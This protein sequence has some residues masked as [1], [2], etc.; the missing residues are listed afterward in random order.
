[1]QKYEI[2]EFFAFLLYTSSSI[3][4]YPFFTFSS[5]LPFQ[6]VNH[7]ITL[8]YRDHNETSPDGCQQA[9]IC[10]RA[11]LSWSGHEVPLPPQSMPSRRDMTSSTFMP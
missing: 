1:M 10:L 5:Y 7:K 2:F 9:A 3:T 11:Q 6:N 8:P 4:K